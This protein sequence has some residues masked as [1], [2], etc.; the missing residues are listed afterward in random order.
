M[1]PNAYNYESI[2]NVN[3]SISCLYDAGCFTGPGNPYWLNDECYAWV[4]S[5]DDYCCE[6]EWDEVCQLTYDYCDST[7]TGPMPV[8]KS[9]EE[10]I[11]IYP[12]PTSGIVNINKNVDINVFNY[13][14]DMII[15]K[16]NVNVLD[17]SRLSPGMYILQMN[18]K[19]KSITKQL[20]KK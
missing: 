6:N 5:V 14:G 4:I 19:N 9:L 17:V 2:A 1:D 7:Y 13:I 3:D 10:D 8:R 20:I 15:S 18:Y 12:N 11:T 16:Q